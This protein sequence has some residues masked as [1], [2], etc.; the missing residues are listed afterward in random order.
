MKILETFCKYLEIH[1]TIPA[2][3]IYSI[4]LSV[5]AY[6]IIKL[7]KRIVNAFCLHFEQN[8]K[9]RYLHNQKYNIVLD[10]VLI[11]SWYAI[12]SQY[13]DKLITIISF[14]SAA[15]TLALR[16]L[17]FNF[18]SGIYIK[19]KKPF[20]IED[21]IEI[22]GTIGD[23][24]NI[25]SLNF[26]V[27][28]INDKEHGEQSTGRIITYPNSY[29]STK[30]IKNYVKEFK[31]V[32][33]ELTVKITIDSDVK[34]AKN[35]LYKIINNNEIVKSIPKKMENQ[36]NTISL[37]YRIYFNKLKPIIYTSVVDDHIE[38]SIRFLVHPRKIRL[39][40]NDVWLKILE[41]YQKGQLDLYKD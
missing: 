5:I 15:L 20:S 2:N 23:V 10:I 25:N 41:C 14:V 26:E 17:V 38:L 19:F 28:E 36:I 7:I 37:D 12:W 33:D 39:V 29:A 6:L 22:D 34:K 40:E 31:Y 16:E 27:L 24:I 21:R 3:I 4:T 30:S 13:L 32:W 8:A 9:K 18:F 11:L 35:I 1:T